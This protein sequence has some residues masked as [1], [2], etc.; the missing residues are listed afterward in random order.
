MFLLPAGK[1][2]R[3]IITGP[4]HWH[5]DVQSCSK[6]GIPMLPCELCLNERD[7]A[8]QVHLE[9]LDRAVLDLDPDVKLADLMPSDHRWLVARVV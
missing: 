7:P 2:E 9:D 8:I 4:V 1:G 5:E 6:H 3:M